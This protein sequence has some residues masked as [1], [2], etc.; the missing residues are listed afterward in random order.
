[1][2]LHIAMRL[3]KRGVSTVA[4]AVIV[5]LIVVASVGTYAYFTYYGTGK[6][7]TPLIIY[8]A[9]LYTREAS[10]LYS[11]FSNSTGVPYAAPNGGG[12]NA[13]ATQ[14]SQG[15]P[16]SV[17][18]SVAKSTLGS[19][20]LGTQ[21]SGWGIAFAADQMTLGYTSAAG[22]PSE[23]QQI[24]N[25]YQAASS[26]NSTT[27]WKA[28]FTDLVSGSVKVGISNPNTDPAGFRGWLVLEAAGARYA[29][30]S[31][32]F[33]DMLL[34]SKSNFTASSASDLVAPLQAGQIQFLFMYKSSAISDNVQALD[35]PNQVNLGDPALSSFY[36]QF[37]Y[38]TT[39]GLQTGGP[40][41][42]Y[43][44][45]PKDS[46]ETTYALQLVVYIV[47]HSSDMSQFG[48]VPLSPAKLYNSTEVPAPIAQLLTSGTLVESGT[49]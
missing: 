24:L 27:D 8:T 6:P 42:L 7:K 47:Q 30:N 39:S 29:G 5:I 18:I 17:F 4:V 16:V 28:F 11:G 3:T 45:V 14:I 23:F 35:L 44:T 26:S 10:Y 37:S 36:A 38:Q 13:L 40:I 9:D 20:D 31:S 25:A 34:Q 32:Y 46:T 1:M 43:V 22:Q 49:I 41:Y 48:M 33:T 2:G 12:S 21:Y 15:A 19:A